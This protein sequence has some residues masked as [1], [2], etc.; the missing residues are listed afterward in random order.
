MRVMKWSSIALVA[1]SACSSSGSRTPSPSNAAQA[2]QAA[3][4]DAEDAAA[5]AA[6]G[7]ADAA[8]LIE[9]GLES[10]R[11]CPADLPAGAV[12][13]DLRDAWTPRLFA[14]AADGATPSFRATYLQLASE[15]DAKGRP[16]APN[17]A[18][19]E[20]Y[21]IVPSL[22][23][24]RERFAQTARYACRAA[25]DSAPMAT[26]ARPFGQEHAGLVKHGLYQ[27]NVLGAQLE[28][29]RARRSLPNV[30]ALA[31]DPQHRP[32]YERWKAA[33]EQHAGFLAAQRHL[34]CEGYLKER[35]VDGLFTWSTGVALEF[36]QRRNFLMPNY[37]LDPETRAAL[38][39]DPR[40]LDFRLALRILRERVVDAT[41]LIED[42]TAGEG[43]Q[44][45]L[46]RMLDPEAM[47]RARG[48]TKAMPDAAPD[49]IAV[50]TEAAAKQLGWTGPAETAAWLAKHPGGTRVA[51]VLPPPP[52][53]HSAHMEL[54]AEIDRGDVW[55]D[56]VPTPRLGGR[57]PSLV[58]YVDD[59]G[60]RRPLVRWPST[61]GGWSDVSVGST[62]VQR[63]KESDV[64]P[65]VWRD[66]FAAPTWLPPASTPDRDLVRWVSA[67]KWELKRSIMG[68]GPRAAFGM[69]LLPHLRPVKGANG[70]EKYADNGIGTHGS[71][72]VMSIVH[73]TSHGCHRLYNQLAVRLGAFLLHHRNHVVKGQR[74][75]LYRRAVRFNGKFDAKIDTRGF[76]YEFT[77]P[78]PVNV[79]TG[80]IRS[81]RKVPPAASAPA[82]P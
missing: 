33:D 8:L 29:E 21:G 2:E 19:G 23:I 75:E 7:C 15:R 64:G 71:A 43:P 57:R 79:T 17:D 73:G 37:R 6:P 80:T 74:K 24:V 72:T 49:L 39:T 1:I 31:A 46:G 3:R 58:L 34:V 11:V 52:A 4:D 67:G 55:Y 44:A 51:L 61:I 13:V 47:R 14:P 56:D 9:A 32:T 35:D 42:G 60:T 16:L 63:W 62:V 68:P 76:Q 26:L 18:L 70:V 12:V 20:L 40:E 53:Y 38:A 36:F 48:R 59:G 22:A 25:I 66:L 27:R 5:D 41:G 77:P 50:A 28:R 45:I 81:A 54:V 10:G 69:V 78:V 65:R 82:R 30:A